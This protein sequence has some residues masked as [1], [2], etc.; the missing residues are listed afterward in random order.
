MAMME[1]TGAPHNG[2][3]IPST[4]EKAVIDDTSEEAEKGLRQEIFDDESQ[5]VPPEIDT[6]VKF[7]ELVPDMQ[8][9][10]QSHNPWEI[11]SIYELLYFNCPSC[12]YK[13]SSKEKFIYHACE[14]HPEESITYLKRISDNSLNDILCPWEDFIK[15]EPE[16]DDIIENEVKNEEE[17][18]TDNLIEE[19]LINY[20]DNYSVKDEYFFETVD[21]D[22][23]NE[24]ED[25]LDDCKKVPN[26]NLKKDHTSLLNETRKS[27]Q[28]YDNS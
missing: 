14:I 16:A 5:N 9:S 4:N 24:T 13:N 6:Q 10:K 27:T 18:F 23:F 2:H 20:D 21:N 22:E 28:K 25:P 3:A 19:E 1:L 7:K 17:H 26:E 11:E 12:S 15:S 8:S